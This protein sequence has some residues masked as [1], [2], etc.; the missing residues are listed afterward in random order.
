[1]DQSSQ[2]LT[3]IPLQPSL[4]C[5]HWNVLLARH[6]QKRHALFERRAQSVETIQ[7]ALALGLAQPDQAH[8]TR[9]LVSHHCQCTPLNT[10]ETAS[11]NP[12]GYKDARR[13]PQWR[14]VPV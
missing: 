8:P 11:I 3:F 10:E 4:R 14:L 7:G 2:T 1:M 12:E 6:S 5:A 9:R 13:D